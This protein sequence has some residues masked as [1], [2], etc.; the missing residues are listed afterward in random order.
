MIRGLES[1]F[2]LGETAENTLTIVGTG[3]AD[4]AA[5]DGVH[6]ARGDVGRGDAGETTVGAGSEQRVTS[7]GLGTVELGQEHR[8]L[9]ALED[10]NSLTGLHEA[11]SFGLLVRHVEQLVAVLVV[12]GSRLEREARDFPLGVTER[13]RTNL[14]QN[15][16]DR[17]V[18]VG[19]SGADLLR[20][21]G[22]GAD[23]IL[24]TREESHEL[25]A[26]TSL[27]EREERKNLVR[28]IRLVGEEVRRGDEYV[29][30]GS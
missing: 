11:A 14:T 10:R 7:D 13:S 17:A 5:D 8:D 3:G 28:V 30:H 2:D 27:V 22:F 19:V 24:I 9:T 23:G 12:E 1:D 4:A 21:I 18:D 26:Q 29:R 15:A 20:A 25:T 6:E 16:E